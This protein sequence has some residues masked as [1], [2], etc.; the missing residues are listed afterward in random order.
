MIKIKTVISFTRIS[1]ISHQFNGCSIRAL[2]SSSYIL[3]NLMFTAF[4]WVGNVNAL[5]YTK[6]NQGQK[7]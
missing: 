1:L 3:I 2:L 5:V 6:G 4:F 7:D